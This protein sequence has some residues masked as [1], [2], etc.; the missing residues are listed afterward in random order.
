MQ[1]LYIKS[2]LLL[3]N[4]IK[5]KKITS[6]NKFYTAFIEHFQKGINNPLKIITYFI[7]FLHL[8]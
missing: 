6:T 4:F 5:N 1:Y 8:M 3:L 7:Y 2:E